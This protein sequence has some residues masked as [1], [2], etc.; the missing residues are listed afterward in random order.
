MQLLVDHH[1]A[2]LE[3]VVAL[4]EEAAE[5]EEVDDHLVGVDRVDLLRGGVVLPV[6]EHH[7]CVGTALGDALLGVRLLSRRQ[8][9][10]GTGEPVGVGQV[11]ERAGPAGSDVDEAH[12]LLQ[13]REPGDEVELG[14]LRRGVVLGAGV[15]EVGRVDVPVTAGDE[16]EELR[17]LLVVDIGPSLV[18]VGRVLVVELV[19]R[20]YVSS[21]AACHH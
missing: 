12:A 16:Q 3:P 10:P 4:G 14:L 20:A 7:L 9:Q 19:L 8:G 17:R 13:T 15:P 11:R 21:L 5:V 1:A 6:A 18:D 2:G